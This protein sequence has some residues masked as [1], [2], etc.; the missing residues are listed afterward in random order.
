M[1][2]EELNGRLYVRLGRWSKY[3][4]EV[5]TVSEFLSEQDLEDAFMSA[6][7]I[8]LGTSVMPPYFRGQLTYDATLLD[9]FTRGS[10]KFTVDNPTLWPQGKPDDGVKDIKLIVMPFTW[11]VEAAD[12]LIA[13]KGSFRKVLD[14][15]ASRETMER[16]FVEGYQHMTQ[17]I[18]VRQP[19][20]NL[21]DFNEPK[22]YLQDV[23]GKQANWKSELSYQKPDVICERD[24]IATPALI[25]ALAVFVLRTDIYSEIFLT[26]ILLMVASVLCIMYWPKTH[27]AIRTSKRLDKSKPE[28]YKQKVD[29]GVII[30][31]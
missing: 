22:Q 29:N 1:N 17:W 9:V 3:W 23:C 7:Y 13:V 16:G 31:A 2:I 21:G 11:G 26:V 24:P 5:F 20:I 19:M 27:C 6:A 30:S 8:P 25:L 15:W 18:D 14:F 10:G 4:W 12:N 28:W